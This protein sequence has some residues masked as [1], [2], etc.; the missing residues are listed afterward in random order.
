MPSQ[1]IV[2]DN[3]IVDDLSSAGGRCRFFHLL[4]QLNINM[5]SVSRTLAARVCGH[6]CSIYYKL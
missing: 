5:P 4:L 6:A 2:Y 1:R 3:I